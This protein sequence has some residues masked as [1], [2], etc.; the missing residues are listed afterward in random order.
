[1]AGLLGGGC[2]PSLDPIA[3]APGCPDAPLR[4]PAL[5]AD[6][7]ADRLLS[8]FE[9]GTTQLAQVAARDGR[10]IRGRDLTSSSVTIEPSG[11][12]AGRGAW[13]GH[14]AASTPT[15]WGNNWTAEFRMS[16][17]AYD[18]RAYGGFSFWGAFG[19]GNGPS[20]GVPFG[21]TTVDTIRPGCTSHCDDHY[22]AAV[23]LTREWRRY[24]VRFD[25]LTQGIS[26]QVPMR[27]DQLIGLIIWPRQQCDIW[28]DD[29]RLEP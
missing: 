27:R 24:D 16:G 25:D 5:D 26:P 7:P 6:E 13:A 22:M 19:D 4:G 12:C 11:A 17:A 8:D 28:I 1:M 15:S 14:F 18:G 2:A 29:V 9:D 20:F 3:V 23:T 21:I 10:W